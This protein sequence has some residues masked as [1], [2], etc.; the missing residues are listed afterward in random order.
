M[1]FN[2]QLFRYISR[3]MCAS[4]GKRIAYSVGNIILMA[5]AALACWGVV[6]SWNAMFEVNFFAGLL[7]L[8]FCVAAAIMCFVNGVVAQLI[9]L[10]ASAIGI[11]NPEER[12]YNIAAFIIAL[13]S[14]VAIIVVIIV[15]I[16]A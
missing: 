6:Q 14:F 10:V 12:K 16:N 1:S 13:L 3:M 5:L 7:G 8:I 15:L 11:A 4:K 2:Q 9:M